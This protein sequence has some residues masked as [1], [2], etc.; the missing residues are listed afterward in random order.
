MLPVS[1]ISESAYTLRRLLVD[2]IEDI[3]GID[4]ISIGHPG[5]N[6]KKLEDK[7]D[8]SLNIFFYR[9][10]YDGYPSDGGANNP[11]YIRLY[12]LLTAVGHELKDTDSGNTS[13]RDISKG[14]NEL[15]LIGEVMKVLHQNPVFMLTEGGGTT[16]NDLVSL[17][18]VPHTVTLD[19]LNHI[20]STQGGETPYRLSVAYEISLAPVPYA[21]P[22]E[23]SPVVGAPEMHA[24]GSMSREAGS[25]MNGLINLAPAVEITEVDTTEDDWVPHLALVE[26]SADPAAAGLRYVY[27]VTGSLSAN[28]KVLLAGKEGADLSLLWSIWLRKEDNSVIAWN[29]GITDVVTASTVIAN[30]TSGD[31]FYPNRI[32]PAEIDNRRV[33]EVRLP[34]DVTASDIKTWQALLYAEREWTHEFPDGSGETVTTRL[35]SNILLLYG[36]GA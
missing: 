19:D 31:S 5:V 22:A 15:R 13:G 6:L 4:R 35:R 23:S 26:D 36:S 16:G 24:W 8:S 10:D 1:S 17:Q 18:I 29:E 32:D 27:R 30:D 3:S 33:V 9:V 28:L 11:T 14:E 12:C 2:N 20:W 34:A 21:L 25:E 7:E